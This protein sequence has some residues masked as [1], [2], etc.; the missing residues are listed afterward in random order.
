MRTQQWFGAAWAYHD[1]GGAYED[2]MQP[3]EL[4]RRIAKF[5]VEHDLDGAKDLYDVAGDPTSRAL[6][7][8]G[9]AGVRRIRGH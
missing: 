7:K 5:A 1:S 9:L 4:A 8:A 3:G 2:N 6:M